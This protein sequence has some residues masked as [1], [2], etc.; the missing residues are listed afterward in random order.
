RRRRDL[1]E[2]AGEYKDNDEVMNEQ[3][4]IVGVQVEMQ[5]LDVVKG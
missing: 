3:P 1:D 5:T 4:D 2:E